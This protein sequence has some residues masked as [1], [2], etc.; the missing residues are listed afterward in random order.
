VRLH[1]ANHQRIWQ[2]STAHASG[3]MRR[4]NR[5]NGALCAAFLPSPQCNEG[6]RIGNAALATNF[7]QPW[8]TEQERGL[9][10]NDWTY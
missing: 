2:G 1:I 3:G 8:R 4:Y 5:T 10:V 6:T 9:E 7:M